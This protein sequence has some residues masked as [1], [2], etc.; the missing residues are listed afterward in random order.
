MALSI[1]HPEAG[2][3]ARELAARRGTTMTDAIIGALREALGREE[4]RRDP[5]E[6][7]E[8]LMEISKRCAALP[9]LDH[10]SED[11][12]LGYPEMFPELYG[13]DEK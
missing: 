9:V 8:R 2:R 6:V 1:R 12:I 3:L 5:E 4:K 11:E 13:R 7:Y 10:R